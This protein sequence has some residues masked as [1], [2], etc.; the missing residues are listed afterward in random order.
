MLW[1]NVVKEQEIIAFEVN[2]VEEVY[3]CRKRKYISLVLQVQVS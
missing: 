3:N 2:E 1:T